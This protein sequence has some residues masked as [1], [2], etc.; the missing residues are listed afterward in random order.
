MIS[1][2][3]PTTGIRDLTNTLE[4]INNQT[5][6]NYE[7]ITIY[8]KSKKGANWARNK[9]AN[10]AK[11]EYLFFCDD[12]I[13]L[14][15]WALEVLLNKLQNTNYAYSYGWYRLD[16][17]VKCDTHFN[18]ETLKKINY[19]STMSLIKKDI[20]DKFGFDE[21]IQRLQDWDL[22]LTLLEN[23]YYGVYSGYRIFSTK[24]SDDG[25]TSE[26]NIPYSEALK[27]IKEKHHIG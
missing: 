8:D 24:R 6:K 2:I 18:P 5:Y 26:K 22:W 27:I 20:F 11:G 25:I 19:I 13:N 3:I 12:D 4:S 23:D 21:S 1:I 16:Q 14:E 17:E 7:I 10:Q 15:P 9:G